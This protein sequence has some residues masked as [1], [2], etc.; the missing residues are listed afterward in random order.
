[1]TVNQM[2]IAADKGAYI[3]YYSSNFRPLQWSW[4]EFMQAYKVVGCDRIIAGTDGGHFLAPPPVEVM[5]L[6]ITGMLV[7]GIPDNDVE[8][9]VKS[10]ASKLLY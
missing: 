1:M 4:D 7:R 3:G 6:F 9:M 2:K 10:N 8:E 5:R